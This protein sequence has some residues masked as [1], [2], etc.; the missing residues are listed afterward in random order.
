VSCARNPTGSGSALRI[1]IEPEP[2]I[3]T[4]SLAIL[5]ALH[6][7]GVAMVEFRQTAGSAPVFMEVN[8]RFWN[9][10]PLACYAGVDFPSLL[11]QMLE[12]GDVE[13]QTSFRAG[14]RC[15]WLL[16]D[17]R[18]LVEVWR[19]A[20]AGYPKPYP[21]RFSTLLAV[22]TPVPGT[23]HDNFQLADPLPELGD[24]LNF[25]ERVFQRARS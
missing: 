21:G 15:R 6:W 16:G 17:F 24:W 5:Q 10:L 19:G 9:S 18:H 1:S 11:A 14:V 12:T 25:L 8:G 20:P 13:K 7:H 2:Q 23:F 4:A 22:M 3:R